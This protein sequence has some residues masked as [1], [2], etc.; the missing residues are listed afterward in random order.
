LDRVAGTYEPGPGMVREFKRQGNVD[1][2]VIRQETTK[3][4]GYHTDEAVALRIFEVGL[5]LA[6]KVASGVHAPA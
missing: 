4:S 3:R 1:V 2:L 5:H 6:E